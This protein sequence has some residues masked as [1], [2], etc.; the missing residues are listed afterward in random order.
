MRKQFDP[1][2]LKQAA[3]LTAIPFV[4]FVG[5][6]LG[7]WLGSVVDH[8]WATAPWGVAVGSLLGLAASGRVTADYIRQAQTFTK[9][10]HDTDPH[11]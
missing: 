9:K 10:H 3:L 6:A 7:F 4:L 11:R 1:A 5:P 2:L 8:R